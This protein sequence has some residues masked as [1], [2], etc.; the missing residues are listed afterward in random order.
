MSLGPEMTKEG[1]YEVGDQS[2]FVDLVWIHVPSNRSVQ[3]FEI[4]R[5]NYEGP[6]WGAEPSDRSATGYVVASRTHD[7]LGNPERGEGFWI[8]SFGA[9]LRIAR[10]TR[11]AILSESAPVRRANQLTFDDVLERNQP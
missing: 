10:G 11:L 3:V 2:T 6:V 4:P 7:S 8:E 1:W 5:A 9:A